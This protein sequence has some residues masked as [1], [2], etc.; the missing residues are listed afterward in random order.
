LDARR[1]TSVDGAE[2]ILQGIAL[3]T[4]KLLDSGILSDPWT[5]LGGDGPDA[6][7]KPHSLSESRCREGVL[8]DRVVL[9]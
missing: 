6:R 5:A 2:L 4:P 1:F 8:H 9:P 7:L 3:G